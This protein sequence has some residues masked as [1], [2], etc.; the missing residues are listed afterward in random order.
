MDKLSVL[1]VAMGLGL[2]SSIVVAGYFVLK[3]TWDL[4]LSAPLG[5][6]AVVCILG[7]LWACWII[8]GGVL[9]AACI[10][11]GVND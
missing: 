1:F 8:V 10:A 5:H 9:G 11:G 3:L 2:W 4:T 6:V 7:V